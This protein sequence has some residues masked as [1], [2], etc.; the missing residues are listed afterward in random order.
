MSELAEPPRKCPRV[1]E[2]ATATDDALADTDLTRDGEFWFDDGSVVLIAGK[3]AFK[4]YRG[5][6][7][8]QS[9]IFA[10]MFATAGPSADQSLEG[11]PVV[12][13][14]DSAE[15]VRHFLM[16][17]LSK[18]Q[19]S[20]FQTAQEVRFP[21]AQLSALVRLSHKYQVEDLQTQALSALRMYFTDS[22]EFWD[23]ESHYSFEEPDSPAAIE[24]VHLA[25]LT[26]TPSMLPLAMY[27][28]ASGGSSVLDGCRREDGTVVHLSRED[29]QRVMDGYGRLQRQVNAFNL[30]IFTT[31]P[32]PECCLPTSCEATLEVIRAAEANENPSLKLLHSWRNPLVGIHLCKTC[33]ACSKSA[34]S[35]AVAQAAPHI[36]L[37]HGPL[38]CR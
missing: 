8:A 18:T 35:Q 17:L 34:T 27:V 25:I 13:L 16:A 37:R 2:G 29:A 38:G 11:C 30:A 3:V 4:I 19:R 36:R 12:H 21:I 6:L 9:P 10:D 15:D 33:A 32:S 26:D 7:A 20:F 1:Q 24:V 14:S 31:T 5:L 23:S 22:L 28:C